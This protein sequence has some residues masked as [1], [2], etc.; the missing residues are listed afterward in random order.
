MSQNYEEV[1]SKAIEKLDVI[2]SEDDKTSLV[3]VLKNTNSM[4]KMLNDGRE[5]AEL[6]STQVIAHIIASFFQEL[7]LA[8]RISF[9][10]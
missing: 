7:Y 9:K 1:V 5:E 8:N 4:V 6:I 2:I 10:E 3:L